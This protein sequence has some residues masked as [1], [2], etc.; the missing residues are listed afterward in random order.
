MKTTK[1]HK[2]LDPVDG[3]RMHGKKPDFKIRP[4]F[5]VDELE[6]YQD[7]LVKH[8]VESGTFARRALLL[9]MGKTPADV[10][11]GAE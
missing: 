11:G 3:P 2:P 4:G 10:D 7:H 9:A 1:D 5:T 8:G 6:D